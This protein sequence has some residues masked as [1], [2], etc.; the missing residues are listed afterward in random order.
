MV[1]EIAPDRIGRHGQLQEWVED[2]DDPNNKHRHV[3]HLWAVHPGNEITWR[4][5]T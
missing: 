3:S 2:K 1:P 5:L 4:R